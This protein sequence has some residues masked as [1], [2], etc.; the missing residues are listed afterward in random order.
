M[1]KSLFVVSCLV[2]MGTLS[3]CGGAGSEGTGGQDAADT[4]T[5]TLAVPDIEGEGVGTPLDLSGL[6]EAASDWAMPDVV[7]GMGTDFDAAADATQEGGFLWPCDGPDDCLSG[8]CVETGEGTVCTEP[9]TEECPAGWDC[10]QYPPALPDLLFVCVKRH[11]R[12]CLPC[13]GHD[14]CAS[15]GVASGDRCVS[16]GA[17][18]AFCGG[19]CQAATDCP[20]GFECEEVELVGGGTDMQCVPASGQCACSPLATSLAAETECWISGDAGTCKGYRHCDM[21]GLTECDA[22]V[23]AA[24]TC[25]GL[26]DDCDGAVDEELGTIT[27]GLGN[28]EHTVESCVEALPQECDP[29]EGAVEELC[30][31]QDDDCDGVGDEGFPDADGDGEADCMSTD[32]D[33]DGVL[34]GLDNCP[35][36]PNPG[37]ENFELDAQGDACDL[38]DDNDQVADDQDCAPLDPAV[39]PGAV[40]ACN[41]QDDDCDGQTD[42]GFGTISCGMGAC[43][44]AIDVC[45]GGALQECD[46]L[47]GSVPE[48]CDGMDNDCD[49]LSDEGFG[50][51]DQDGQAD[52]LDVDD[53]GDGTVD[54]VDNCPLVSNPG[55]ADSDKDGFG[56]AC[57]GDL[58]GDGVEDGLDNCPQAPNPGQL[59]SDLDGPGDVCD[60]DDDNDGDADV[61]DCAPLDPAVSHGAA[62][63]CNG[64]DDDCD[65]QTDEEG[66]SGCNLFYL[67]LDA[68]G[69]GVLGQSACLCTAASLHTAVQPGDCKPLRDDINPGEDEACDGE[70]D[71]C[72][73]SVDEGLGKSTCGLGQCTHSVDNCVAGVMQKCD[74]LEGATPEECDSIDNDCDSSVDEELGSTT[75]GLGACTHTVDNCVAGVEQKCDPLEGAAQEGCDS[76]DNDCDGSVDEGLGSTTCGL[77]PC[78]HVQ[79]NCVAGVPVACD[80]LLGAVPESFNGLDD[81]CDG[82]VDEDFPMGCADGTR[83]GF[84]NVLAFPSIAACAGTF[85]GWID[86]ASAKSLCAVGWHVCN[87]ADAV[88]HTI[89]YEQA[90]SFGGCFAIDAA[91]DCNSCFKHCR[92]LGC[93]NCCVS[94]YEW[95]ADMG[96]MGSGC[97]DSG[98]GQQSCLAS[99]RLD[100]S[101]NTFG[102]KWNS[103]LAGVV[104]CKD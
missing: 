20:E 79:T 47:E 61:A 10:L 92:D 93:M 40:E 52:C 101:T 65:G 12:L 96:G 39:H 63:A 59:D 32:D 30:N 100:A 68:D 97:A 74:P 22:S 76:V 9:C 13:S 21:E 45:S 83:E 53:D 27:C 78:E 28:C 98:A 29:L 56:D 99:G 33:G 85:A 16:H 8:F 103:S 44:H 34:D 82:L 36:T 15:G 87:G 81:D 90:K 41:G 49:G 17:D 3:A 55:Q 11:V 1:R 70:D 95:D 62:E 89:A 2:L 60:L 7:D 67:D 69:Y 51:L 37:Q 18:G 26:D 5:E 38:D 66:A 48:E 71:D 86:E 94:N 4:G 50:D 64:K 43:D 46:P 75:C 84:A 72:D 25:N 42:E 14:D 31:G 24:E 6:P 54:S 19:S 88:V 80:P 91:H 58:D 77:G 102:C 23:P 57:D 104:C 35:E 73:S